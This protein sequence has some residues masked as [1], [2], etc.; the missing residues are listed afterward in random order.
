[1]HKVFSTENCSEISKGKRKMTHGKTQLTN[2]YIM[3]LALFRAV[4]LRWYNTCSPCIPFF[5]STY[6]ASLAGAG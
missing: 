6:S 1:M 5:F 4:L 2:Q 3:T